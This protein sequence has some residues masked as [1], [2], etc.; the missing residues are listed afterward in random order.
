MRRVGSPSLAATGGDRGG[1][2]RR[3]CS[4]S[5]RSKRRACRQGAECCCVRL[6]GGGRDVRCSEQLTS[7]VSLVV[8][9]QLRAFPRCRGCCISLTA[10]AIGS[11][12]D[13]ECDLLCILR[14]SVASFA[15][16]FFPSG[17]STAHR[18]GTTSGTF[19]SMQEPDRPLHPLL[20]VSLGLKPDTLLHLLVSD[21]Y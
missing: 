18:R 8:A 1:S 20:A 14:H 16:A 7:V 9:G 12:L 4:G 13:P 21:K 10:A 5:A 15:R 2:S 17:R 6:A 19:D 11:L 3:H